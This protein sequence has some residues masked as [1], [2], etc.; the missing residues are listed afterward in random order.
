MPSPLGHGLA[1]LAIG[2]AAEP[3]ATDAAGRR[4]TKFA[5]LGAVVAAL[6]DADLLY[7]AVHR[8]VSHSIGATAL[9]IIVTA[10]VTGWVT[11]K[12]QWRWVLL[13]GAAHFSHVAMDW[14]G[15]DRYPPTGI[16]ALWPFSR[17]FYISGW[18]V[19]PPTERRLYLPGAWLTNVRALIA[20]AG[21]MGP[22][23]VFAFLVR[24]IRRSRVPT[25]ARDGRR[26][27][28]A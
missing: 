18:D 15:T 8:G 12:I 21:L 17:R 19:F 3:P 2:F 4:L 9:L 28:S 11:G 7:P 23:A 1:G 20:E 25:S 26:R 16:E 5:W 22:L 6:P 24:R 27:P 13:I 14:M 10:A